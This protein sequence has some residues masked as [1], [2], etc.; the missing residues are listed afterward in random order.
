[1]KNLIKLFVIFLLTT[2]YAN[3]ACDFIIDIGDKGQKLFDK[4]MPPLPMFEGQ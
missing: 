3:A 2:T 1:M 4:F